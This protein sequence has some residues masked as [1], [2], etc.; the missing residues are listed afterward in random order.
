[1]SVAPEGRGFSIRL[2]QSD[3]M[4]ERKFSATYRH[5]APK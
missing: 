4:E 2:V 1:M 5:D 3:E